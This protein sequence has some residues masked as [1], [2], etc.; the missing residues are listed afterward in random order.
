[1]AIMFQVIAFCFAVWV[2]FPASG[3]RTR[4]SGSFRLVSEEG[5]VW[6]SSTYAVG[7]REVVSFYSRCDGLSPLFLTYRGN[8]FTVRCV[9]VFT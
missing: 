8:S 6:C 7:V 1:M 9:Q 5:D 2:Y 4:E 3:Y